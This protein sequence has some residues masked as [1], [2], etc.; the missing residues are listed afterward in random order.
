ML[1]FLKHEI[2]LPVIFFFPRA[3]QKQVV[4]DLAHGP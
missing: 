2:E 1:F 4:G 3:T